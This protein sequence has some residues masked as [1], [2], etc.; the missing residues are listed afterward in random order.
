MKA[1][2]LQAQRYRI[3]AMG[4]LGNAAY[5]LIRQF[6]FPNGFNT[7]RDKI[8]SAD[9]DRLL[10]WGYDQFRS[11]LKK[12]IGRG[13]IAIGKWVLTASDD[14]VMAFLKDAFDVT[15]KYP[16][17]EWTGWRVLGTVNRGNGFPIYTLE[18]FANRSGVEVYS[19]ECAPNVEKTSGRNVYISYFGV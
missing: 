2:V 3:G 6:R 1:K 16:D 15:T 8:I 12:H 11:V 18:L 17:V 14:Q 4:S 10:G 19:D 13:E 7:D 9:S 5:M